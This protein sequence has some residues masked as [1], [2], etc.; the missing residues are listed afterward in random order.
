[1]PVTALLPWVGAWLRFPRETPQTSERPHRPHPYIKPPVTD[2]KQR[3]GFPTSDIKHQRRRVRF[4][5]LPSYLTLLISS[6]AS[7]AGHQRNFRL[8]LTSSVAVVT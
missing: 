6:V 5:L 8:D 1:I 4:F 7:T 3:P 2:A